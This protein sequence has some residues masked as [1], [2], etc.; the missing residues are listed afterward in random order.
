MWGN[1]ARFGAFPL[2]CIGE[3]TWTSGNNSRSEARIASQVLA[4]R[5]LAAPVRLLAFLGCWVQVGYLRDEARDERKA[6][7]C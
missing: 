2:T 3:A 4:I 5:L 1:R 6:A 7:R